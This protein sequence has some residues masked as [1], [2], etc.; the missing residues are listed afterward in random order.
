[1]IRDFHYLNK[2]FVSGQTTYLQASGFN[3]VAQVVVNFVAVAVTFVD[4]FT[5]VCIV[6]LAAGDQVAKLTTQ[7]HSAAKV[8]AFVTYFGTAVGVQPFCNQADYRVRRV[9][10][11]LGTV[12]V[13]HASYITCKLD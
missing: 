5:A 1:M 2:A 7:A 3:L 13:F 8:R 12:G 6:Y 11:K 10:I 4:F 9:W